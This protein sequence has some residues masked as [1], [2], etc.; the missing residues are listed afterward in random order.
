MG[1]HWAA[2]Q[3]SY[4]WTD[5]LCSELS[6]GLLQNVLYRHEVKALGGK[7]GVLAGYRSPEG[8]FY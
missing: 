4:T 8:S 3:V 2:E 6:K 1:L 5:F 7:E